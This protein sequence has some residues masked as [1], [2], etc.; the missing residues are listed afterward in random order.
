MP[1]L[2]EEVLKELRKMGY[3]IGLRGEKV[4]LTWT[5]EDEP[6]RALAKP[7]LE[8][9]EARKA[10]AVLG[11]QREAINTHAE[12]AKAKEL[13][14]RQGW[15]AVKSHA[16]G[17]QVVMWLTDSTVAVP[18]QWKECTT[19]TLEELAALCMAPKPTAAGLQQVHEAKKL[20][21]S[22]VKQATRRARGEWG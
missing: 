22:E 20:F 8:E 19:Y 13:L 21:V 16:L 3:A 9:L 12:A 18:P 7:L 6:S 4:R 10:E 15:C 2:L 14:S 1:L 11:L 5:G 17:G